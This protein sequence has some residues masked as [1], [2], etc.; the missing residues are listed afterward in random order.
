MK[1]AHASGRRAFTLVELLIVIGII[2]I[3]IAL[4]V[5][6]VQRVRAAAANVQCINNMKQI[7]LGLHQ[8]H[9]TYGHFPSG[10]M[11]SW[12]FFILPYIEQ[13]NL[14]NDAISAMGK[15]QFN[16][17]PD[18]FFEWHAD[19]HIIGYADDALLQ[20]CFTTTVATFQ[21][22]ADPRE[23]GG[24]S[25]ELYALNYART[26]YLGVAGKQEATLLNPDLEG[27][28]GVFPQ[29]GGSSYSTLLNTYHPV[30]R[31]QDITDGLSNTLMVGERPSMN[32]RYSIVVT[33]PGNQIETQ[34]VILW[35]A[36][37]YDIL[38]SRLWA[39][40]R[41][42]YWDSGGWK[43]GGTQ[44]PDLNYFSPGDLT[45]FCHALHFWSFHPGGAN[46]LLCDGSVRTMPYSA[47][48]KLIPLM[49]SIDGGEVL[50]P[51]D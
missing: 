23:N 20:A 13:E 15:A 50:P 21:C 45:N 49:A 48:T 11:P 39:I 34:T 1:P 19:S 47:G 40:M 2:A 25:A 24:M 4:I 5:P 10:G 33:D 14:Y 46:W 36:A 30:V 26:S 38:G 16:A 37:F 28:D 8:Y 51:L 12:T 44:C 43:A 27:E 41:G 29:P 32:S 9:N 42:S 35:G 6:A 18:N 17:H 22:P 7:G 31:I 3:L